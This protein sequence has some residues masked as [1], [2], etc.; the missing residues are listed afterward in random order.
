MNFKGY[1]VGNMAY[2]G[3][4]PQKL[5]K[6]WILVIAVPTSFF[7]DLEC[8]LKCSEINF[9]KNPTDRSFQVVFRTYGAPW[10]ISETNRFCINGGGR[11]KESIQTH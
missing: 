8:H 5:P 9:Y 7:S 1:T 6:K 2:L 10:D 4:F 11:G 3:G